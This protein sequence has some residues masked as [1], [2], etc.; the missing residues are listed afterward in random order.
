MLAMPLPELAKD[1]NIKYPEIKLK[2]ITDN[3]EKLKKANQKEV[4][5]SD[6]AKQLSGTKTKN[7]LYKPKTA[8]N[9]G[10]FGYDPKQFGF[11]TGSMSPPPTGVV[12]PMGP[13]GPVGPRPTGPGAGGTPYNPYGEGVQ[14]GA[15]VANEVDNFLLRF[16]D[17][18]V[19]PGY[20][21]EY[22]IR[23]RM[24]NPNFNQKDLVANPEFAKENYKLLTS[25]WLQLETP[26]TVPAESF[27][28][29]HDVKGYRDKI[30]ETYDPTSKEVETKAINNLL[31]VRDNQAILQVATWMEQVRT[32][33]S[34]REP[35]GA[36]V[37]AEMPVERGGYIGR[38]Q[39]I[40]L[41]L[42]SSETQQYLLREVGEKVVRGKY[43]PK[44]WLVDFSTKSV[45][46]DFEGGRVKSRTKVR[47]DEKGNVVPGERLLDEDVSTEVL[48][49]RPD[50]KLVVRNSQADD[51]DPNRKSVA[52][53]WTRWIQEIEKRKAPGS[54]G[55]P[56]E[57]GP[58]K[59]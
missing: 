57:F 14:P 37:V 10:N 33:G 39:F 26:I 19:K 11:S 9:V 7:D 8:D 24:W 20:T 16:V 34:K 12:G 36:W 6:L 44:G 32:D 17:C 35:V 25:K 42:W 52:S 28:Y 47:F 21:Y 45:L 5:K 23:L 13:M 58:K 43:Q 27:L 38:K 51:T 54:T 53:E 50:G 1:L 3:I 31:Q 49:V 55:M 4:T 18:D 22:R 59:P 46:V 41:P 15:T 29:A 56:D 40:K 48:I 30:N 2:D